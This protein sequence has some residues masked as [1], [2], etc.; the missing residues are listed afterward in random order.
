MF[1]VLL[2]TNFTYQ[3]TQS[4]IKYIF[5]RDTVLNLD[6]SKVKENFHIDSIHT[7]D[8]VKLITQT[9]DW[10]LDKI[11][12]RVS[13]FLFSLYILMDPKKIFYIESEIYQKN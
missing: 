4:Q 12:F 8:K 10:F 13:N 3:L 1:S 5:I 6:L 11:T 2:E 7:D 9:S